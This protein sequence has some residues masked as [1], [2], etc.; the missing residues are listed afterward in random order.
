MQGMATTADYLSIVCGT[1]EPN[2]S[3]QGVHE[4]IYQQMQW[5]MPHTRSCSG[6]PVLL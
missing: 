4:N 1:H 5:D 2:S 6:T 3:Q